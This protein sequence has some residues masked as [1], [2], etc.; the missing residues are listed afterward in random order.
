MQH[1]VRLAICV[2]A[3][4]TAKFKYGVLRVIYKYTRATHR[5]T[6]LL[7]LT[8]TALAEHGERKVHGITGLREVGHDFL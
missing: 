1:A 4:N 7:W 6:G 3:T 2:T 8:V 5:A